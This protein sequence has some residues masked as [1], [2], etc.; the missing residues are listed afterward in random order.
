YESAGEGSYDPNRDYPGPCGTEG[1]HKLKSTKALAQ[2]V[3]DKGI[4][5]SATLHTFY[6]VVAYPWGI[7]T[8]DLSTPYDDLFK[9]LATSAVTESHYPIG[10][11]TEAIYPAD[12]TYEDYAFW[13]H[14]IWSLLF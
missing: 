3:A 6:P 8:H 10:N 7:S 9:M 2:F 1:P 12:G 13:K 14:G 11:S 5:A 4:V